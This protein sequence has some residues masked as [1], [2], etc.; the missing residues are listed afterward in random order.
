MGDTVRDA[1]RLQKEVLRKDLCQPTE[2][3]TS[4]TPTDNPN[5]GES[6][7]DDEG[8]GQGV[9]EREQSMVGGKGR[10][11]NEANKAVASMKRKTPVKGNSGSD[12]FESPEWQVTCVL[13][14][15]VLLTITLLLWT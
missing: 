5:D 6:S 15:F 10:A 8:V 11:S 1:V 12:S 9:G 3:T 4:T 2:H 14:M 13:C 7:E